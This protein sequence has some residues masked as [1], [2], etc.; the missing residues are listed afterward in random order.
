MHARGARLELGGPKQRAILAMLLIHAEEVVATDTLVEAVWGDEA[1]DTT[2]GL[3]RTY[4]SRLRSV[5]SSACCELVGRRPGYVL[6]V[7]SETIDSHRFENL[8]TK[9][10]EAQAEGRHADA[11]A[12]LDTALALWR[13]APF[14]DLA[15][16]EFIT[17]A[18]ARLENLRTAALGDRIDA[19]LGLGRHGEVIGPLDELTAAHPF[20]ERFWAQRILALYRSDRQAEALS[21]YQELRTTLIEQL[22]VEPSPELKDLERAVLGQAGELRTSLSLVRDGSPLQVG[23]PP[24][25]ASAFQRRPS[26]MA[27]MEGA[28]V[29]AVG[30]GGVGK[31]QMAAALFVAAQAQGTRLSVWVDASSRA[32][33]IDTFAQAHREIRHGNIGET[34]AEQLAAAFLDILA[35][36]PERWI[37]VLDDVADPADV[38]GLWPQGSSGQ[39]IATTRRRDFA[40]NDARAVTV[41][42]FSLADAYRYLAG[43]LNGSANGLAVHPCALDQASELAQDLG[44]LPVALAQAATIVLNE[45]I[46]CADYRTRFADQSKRCDELFPPEAAADDYAATVATTW[47]LAIE[48]ADALPPVG[49]AR[50]ALELAAVVDAN[51]APD[52]LWLSQAVHDRRTTVYDERAALRNLHRLSLVDHDVSEMTVRTPALIQRAVLETLSEDRRVELLRLAADAIVEV[53]PTAGANSDDAR[54]L[55]R[56]AATVIGRGSDG[57]WRPHAHAVHFRLGRSLEEVGRLEDAVTYWTNL[58]AEATTWLG[59]DHPDTLTTRAT[60]ADCR[61]EAGEPGAALTDF[62]NVFEDSDRILGDDHPDTLATQQG[63][64]WWMGTVR[65]PRA[66]AAA[67]AQLAEQAIHSF[68]ADHTH[69]LAIRSHLAYWQGEAGDPAAAAATMQHLLLDRERLLGVDHPN[70]VATRH[71]FAWWTGC[72]GN[73]VLAADT[74]TEI[75]VATHDHLG[76]EHAHSLATRNHLAYWEGA[77][78]EPNGAVK[79]LEELLA[80][81]ERIL[82][83]DHPDTFATRNHLAHW[84]GEAGNV[85]AAMDQLEELQADRQHALGADHPGTVATA[86]HLALWRDVA[87]SD[88]DAASRARDV[89][90]RQRHTALRSD[91]NAV[92]AQ[93]GQASWRRGQRWTTKRR[94]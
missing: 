87:S 41:D 50:L 17:P 46:T 65:G 4:V 1:G 16:F 63:L 60:L 23:R 35:T 90:H 54:V 39:V 24:S 88:A 82:G 53:W 86:E 79:R 28:D 31:S 38:I 12:E 19:K 6:Q 67:L 9:G 45:G 5:L 85:S 18:A 37:V 84:E 57:L 77:S 33:I 56:N 30:R 15:K 25:A 36:T 83:A 74:L 14:A 70:T 32:S 26:L 40:P 80:D 11:V 94:L 13:G 72:A 29:V 61:G 91:S 27:S 92:A 8:L 55:R 93:L 7:D 71:G 47:S 66:A 21:T 89:L 22:G 59:S 69:S 62:E 48:R 49:A 52:C 2:E 44:G 34:P 75:L 58:V 43:R 68:G 20:D 81:R 64:F 73:P 10:R 51:G 78:G 3:V 42:A 76:V